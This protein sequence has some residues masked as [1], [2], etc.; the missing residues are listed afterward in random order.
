MT[1]NNNSLQVLPLKN[2]SKS[3]DDNYKKF[4]LNPIL[5]GCAKGTFKPFLLTINAGVRSGK[6]VLI[7][8]LL[9]NPNFGYKQMFDQIYCISPTILNDDSGRFIAKD[10]DIIKITENLDNLDEIVETIANIQKE[11]GDEKGN[12]LIILDDCLGFI[13]KQGGFFNSFLS[14]YRHY[15]ITLWITCQQF[16]AVSV[17]QRVNSGYYILFKSFN[18]KEQLAIEEELS[19]SIPNFWKLYNEATDQKYQFMYCDLEQMK[20]YHNF[21]KLIWEK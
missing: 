7:N 2:L 21:Q 6:T 15:K 12:I 9:Y 1:D 19:G 18:K 13:P 10:D 16:K 4:Q 3:T 14:R 20:V 11:E 8:N 5:P 17:I